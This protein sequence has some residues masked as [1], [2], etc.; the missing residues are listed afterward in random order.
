MYMYVAVIGN[1]SKKYCRVEQM[2]NR[3]FEAKQRIMFMQKARKQMLNFLISSL[4]KVDARISRYTYK[5]NCV[6]APRNQSPLVPSFQLPYKKS[7]KMETWQGRQHSYYHY[8]YYNFPVISIHSSKPMENYKDTIQPIEIISDINLSGHQQ[9]SLPKHLNPNNN[10]EEKQ[11]IEE[12][13]FAENLNMLM[14]S[15]ATEKAN[16]IILRG[17][18]VIPFTYVIKT[19]SELRKLE[20]S[21]SLTEMSKICVNIFAND[22]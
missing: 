18:K 17:V 9:V 6:I 10:P 2:L 12:K 15:C 3:A 7:K 1:I 20:S 11:K 14:S 16:Y 21:G 4:S 19:S 8:N 22:N 5:S 13:L